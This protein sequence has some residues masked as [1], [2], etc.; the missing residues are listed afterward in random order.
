MFWIYQFERSEGTSWND[1]FLSNSSKVF[2]FRVSVSSETASHRYF[3][4]YQNDMWHVRD[5][6]EFRNSQLKFTRIPLLEITKACIDALCECFSYS[7][8]SV[9]NLYS[10]RLPDLMHHGTPLLLNHLISRR[11][12]SNPSYR[13]YIYLKSTH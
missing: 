10:L 12:W 4:L 2:H 11:H 5:V 13:C 3:Y 9:Y 8:H 1:S 6:T 7:C